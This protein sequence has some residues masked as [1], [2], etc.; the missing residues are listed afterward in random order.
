MGQDSKGLWVAMSEPR[1]KVGD[2]V[3]LYKPGKAEHGMHGVVTDVREYDGPRFLD[4][5]MYRSD[6]WTG[7]PARAFVPERWLVRY[8]KCGV[9]TMVP[10]KGRE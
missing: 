9:P 7:Y 4:D 8:K 3:Q 1:F 2:H 5:W 6:R 10:M